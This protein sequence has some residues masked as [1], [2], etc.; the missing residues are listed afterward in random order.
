MAQESKRRINAR[1]LFFNIKKEE[2]G[3]YWPRLTKDKI[4]VR[5][6]CRRVSRRRCVSVLALHPSHPRAALSILPP[7]STPG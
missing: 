3:P 7:C 4:K 5:R 6:G 2:E 1:E